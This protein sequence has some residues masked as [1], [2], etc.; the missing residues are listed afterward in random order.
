MNPKRKALKSIDEVLTEKSQKFFMKNKE[1]LK[2]KSQTSF[3]L[4]LLP[5]E[6]L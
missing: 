1:L 5:F 2:K 6:S 3:I 4:L